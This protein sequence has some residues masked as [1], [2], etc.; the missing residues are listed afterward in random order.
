MAAPA[1]R[2]QL[3]R[4]LVSYAAAGGDPEE[5]WWHAALAVQYA[6]E[7][8][9]LHDDVIDGA[10]MRRGSPTAAVTRGV[11]AA[12][13]EGD[14]LLTTAYRLAARTGS[15]AFV[16]QFARAVERTVAGERLQGAWR[17]RVLSAGEYRAVVAGKSGELL[18]AAFA[19]APL[20]RADPRASAF[21]EVGREV[22]V[23]YQMVDDLLDYCP[24]A[25][26]GK[27]ALADHRQR[28]WTWPLLHAPFVRW[29]DDAE[30]VLRNFTRATDGVV[31]LL[32]ALEALRGV[33]AVTSAQVRR[34]LPDDAIV[35]GL[36]G[37]WLT[38]AERGVEATLRAAARDRSSSAPAP[39]PASEREP[40]S[41]PPSPAAGLPD[42]GA[43]AAFFARN[44]RSFS[45]AAK[46]LPAAERARVADVYAFC[47]VTDDLADTGE[48]DAAGRAARLDAWLALCGRAYDGAGTGVAVLDRVF[49][50]ARRA[51]VPFEY[52]EELIAGMRMDLEVHRYASLSELRVYTYR[53][54]SIVGLWLARLWGVRDAWTLERAADLGH[55]MQLTNI[56]RDVG[57]DWRAGRLYLPADLRARHGVDVALIESMLA[58]APAPARW[59]DLIEEL[60]A[61]ADRGYERA[62]AAIPRLPRGVR[63]AVAA[64]AFIYRGIHDEI[65]WSG[66]DNIGR[67]ARTSAPR[68]LRLA[69][70]AL[71]RLGRPT[72][73]AF[74]PAG[75]PGAR[76]NGTRSLGEARIG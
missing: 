21:V 53:V 63:A 37:D 73:A 31:P 19:A 26:T 10:R 42:E 75:P 55:A 22:G 51:G 64:A 76:T 20:L 56:L 3:I 30:V 74:A 50:D 4:P 54:A 24:A 70:L 46:L 27:S 62:F 16:E 57:E 59:M 66:Y 33:F 32:V 13:V 48:R 60:I 40:V 36:L 9:L 67:R 17:G 6:H 45:F 8:S 29:T 1:L 38:R 12:L 25:D 47:R 14:H 43:L 34:L 2:G 72:G 7:A 18:G 61:E 71:W 69:A 11:T 39:A 65:R 44:S 28:I 35:V 5:R 41:A 23:C 68:K 52:A 58:G 15:L 49:A